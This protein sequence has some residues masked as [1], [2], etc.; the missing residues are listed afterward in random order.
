M[1]YYIITD[2]LQTLTL[3]F[4]AIWDQVTYNVYLN[5]AKEGIC[6]DTRVTMLQCMSFFRP[7]EHE[8]CPAHKY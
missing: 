7:R 5:L 8:I 4:C 3:D 2:L 1:T 6:P